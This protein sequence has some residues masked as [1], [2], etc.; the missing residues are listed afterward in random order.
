VL[1]AWER[2]ATSLWVRPSDDPP[3]IMIHKLLDQFDTV[4]R[5]AGL[6]DLAI[7]VGGD[8]VLETPHRRA[9]ADSVVLWVDHGVEYRLE[10]DAGRS[11]LLTMARALSRGSR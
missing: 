3:E 11:A 1:R 5:V 4:E 10:S 6:G 9:A 8:H 7:Y 2:G